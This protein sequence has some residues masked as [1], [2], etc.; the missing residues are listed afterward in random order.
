[1]RLSMLRKMFFFRLVTSVVQRKVN[2]E[3]RE[4]CEQRVRTFRNYFNLN[5]IINVEKDVFFSSCHER[6][7][8]KS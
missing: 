1:M 5:A 6:S 3:M 4:R 7:T 2:E 8:K